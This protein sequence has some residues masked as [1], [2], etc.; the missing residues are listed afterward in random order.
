MLPRSI[1]TI[2]NEHRIETTRK[3]VPNAKNHEI[4]LR[5]RSYYE[6]P[7]SLDKIVL[8]GEGDGREYRTPALL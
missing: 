8:V 7:D 5:D 2:V 1:V 6:R 4:T 3:Q